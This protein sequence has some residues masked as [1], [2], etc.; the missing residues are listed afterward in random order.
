[1]R[2]RNSA[3]F[4][5][6]CVAAVPL[7]AQTTAQPLPQPAMTTTTTTTTTG[8]TPASTADD[9]RPPLV[10][11]FY[12]GEAVDNFAAD[13]VI[14]YLNPQAA[15]QNRLRAIGGIDFGYRLVGAPASP[16][17]LWV[18][19]ETVHGVRSRDVDCNDANNVK[20]SVCSQ[21]LSSDVVNA[22]NAGTYNP[23]NQLIAILRNASSLEAFGGFRFEAP[24]LLQASTESPARWFVRGELGF[25]AVSGG[26]GD[27]V[28]LRHVGVGAMA[29]NGTFEGSFLEVGL[30]RNDLF[31]RNRNKRL[32]ID[33]YL[34]VDP[35][36][37][38]MLGFDKFAG[39]RV[40]PFVEFTGDFDGGS[41]SD[42]I[43]TFFGLDFNLRK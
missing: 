10:A 17:Q 14:K 11:S 32:L 41:G 27:V 37:I 13:Q 18:Y 31:E 22:I 38:P 15:N 9:T 20:L 16:W 12:L 5:L 39:S 1:M 26:G 19:G 6:L 23:G 42:S 40:R 24:P 29:I 36:A 34:S 28:D 2:I 33:G 4:L 7:A 35:G 3:A 25:L 30:G 43:Q 8:T 21:N